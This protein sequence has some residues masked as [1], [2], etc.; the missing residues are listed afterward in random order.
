[1]RLFRNRSNT[2]IDP[3]LT[4]KRPEMSHIHSFH[5]DVGT[6]VCDGGQIDDVAMQNLL[7]SAVIETGLVLFNTPVR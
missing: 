2:R 4:L 6:R 1:M 7:V 5:R 3:P